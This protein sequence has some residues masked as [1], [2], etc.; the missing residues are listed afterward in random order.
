[1]D[2]HNMPAERALAH[3]RLRYGVQKHHMQKLKA[4]LTITNYF[5]TCG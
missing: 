5:Q 1:M 2:E 4:S 3:Q